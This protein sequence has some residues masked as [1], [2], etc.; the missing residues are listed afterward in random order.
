MKEFQ[1]TINIDAPAEKVWDALTNVAEW[2]QW[3]PN[4]T[5][6]DGH[7]ALDEK[8][9]VQTTLSDRAFPVTVSELI[10]NQKMVWSSGMPLG[11]FK[12]ARTFTLTPKDNGTTDVKTHEQ[13]TGLLLPIIGRTIPDL[14]PSF[15]QFA[16]ALKSRVESGG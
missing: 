12:G 14:Q 9:T 7:V 4:V 11:L 10:P 8:I 3:E 6:V 16:E 15:N 13:F 2:S 5:N 1:A